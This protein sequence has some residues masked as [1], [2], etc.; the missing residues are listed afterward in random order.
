[1]IGKFIDKIKEAFTREK[2]ESIINYH[3]D[4]LKLLLPLYTISSV[5]NKLIFVEKLIANQLVVESLKRITRIRRPREVE[6]DGDISNDMSFPSGHV[7][8]AATAA[9]FYYYNDKKQ[10]KKLNIY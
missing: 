2:G 1:M 8:A 9:F 4:M 10:I 3:G 6:D 7:G 5:D